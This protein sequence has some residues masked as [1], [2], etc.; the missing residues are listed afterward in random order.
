[1]SFQ[2]SGYISDF[3]DGRGIRARSHWRV[4]HIRCYYVSMRHANYFGSLYLFQVREHD[5]S[6]LSKATKSDSFTPIAPQMRVQLANGYGRF[7]GLSPAHVSEQT[8]YL[9]KTSKNI[10]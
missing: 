6:C 7:E 10:D 2:G 3:C 5:A 9:H 8:R 4:S 1:M